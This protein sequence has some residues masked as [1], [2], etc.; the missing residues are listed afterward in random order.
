MNNT[1]T[2][3]TF[4]DASYLFALIYRH[5][6]FIFIF[7]ILACI[8]SIIISFLLPVWYP[9]TINF[10][11]PT[12]SGSNLTTS[13]G[14]LS[15]MMKDIGL[16]KIGGKKSQEY[17]MIVFLESRTVIDSVIHKY[18]LAKVYDIPDTMIS[19]VR[20]EFLSNRS[21][22]YTDEGN[23]ELTIWDTDKNRAAAI[24]NDYI[25]I[26]N[27]IANKVHQEEI[28]VNIDYIQ[29][30][31]NSIDSTINATSKE[32]SKISKSNLMFSPEQQASA[33]STALS[34]IKTQALEYEI[35]YD[36]YNKNYGAD[37][38][39]TK[40]L[41][42]MLDA[43][44]SKVTDA[45]K[46]PGFIGNFALEDATP[47]AVNYLTKYADIEALTTTKALLVTTLEK[48]LIDSQNNVHNFFVIDEAIPADK[49]GKPKRAFIVAG[50]TV[51]AFVLCVFILLFINS[52]K[53]SIRNAKVIQKQSELENKRLKAIAE[54]NIDTT[55]NDAK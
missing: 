30:R 47:V 52:I 44:N 12:E 50:S 46:K 18:N 21:V 28:Q 42:E 39:T 9:S 33:A 53:L 24:A 4:S 15:S 25:K 40:M 36:F 20:K 49:K 8:A 22:T 10:V 45:F 54:N 5:K 14:G 27:G 6:L 1:E 34:E 29:S 3:K 35:M 41:K 55:S 16:S 48:N 37:D 17:T 7:T 19:K 11:P 51:G 13:S 31:I 23:Y 26:T 2:Q 43:A 32:L 38:P